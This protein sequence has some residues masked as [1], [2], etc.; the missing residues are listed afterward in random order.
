MVVYSR[1]IACVEVVIRNE[2][3]LSRTVSFSVGNRKGVVACSVNNI[4]GVIAVGYDTNRIIFTAVVLAHFT[5]DT[6]RFASTAGVGYV[7]G[8][9]AVANFKRGACVFERNTY[10]TACAPVG[11]SNVTRVGATDDL[12]VN[13]AIVAVH[14]GGHDTAGAAFG[15]CNVS[16]VCTVFNRDRASKISRDGNNT[17]CCYGTAV[18]AHVGDRTVVCRVLDGDGR[19]GC[20]R[21]VFTDGNKTCYA[22]IV[23]GNVTVVN[24]FFHGNI[25]RYVRTKANKTACGVSVVVN[26]RGDIAVVDAVF[27]IK[28][29]M[30]VSATFPRCGI[31]ACGAFRSTGVAGDVGIVGAVC[32]GD[33]SGGIS[34]G[35][36]KACCG[37]TNERAVYV[38]VDKFSGNTGCPTAECGRTRRDVVATAGIKSVGI[39]GYV[40]KIGVAAFE[41]CG[42]DTKVTCA[43]TSCHDGLF[44]ATEG[45]VSHGAAEVSVEDSGVRTFHLNV[46]D[47]EAATVKGAGETGLFV[48]ISFVGLAFKVKITCQVI[49]SVGCHVDKFINGGDRS[50]C[51]VVIIN[52]FCCCEYGDGCQYAYDHTNGK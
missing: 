13:Y 22:A 25:C 48:N 47:R 4:T 30:V 41:R 35:Y 33:V 31:E 10:D 14:S 20:G 11:S 18:I 26:T 5:H 34:V 15:A 9:V 1:S 23:C 52:G 29:C 16:E 19:G 7:A 8:V 36:H 3:I 44:F 50:P 6:C 32:K 17:C 27:K 46:Q 40:F 38:A 45:N 21:A 49:L 37:L 39:N 2:F 42:N 12:D 24:A 51:A 28:S 43:G